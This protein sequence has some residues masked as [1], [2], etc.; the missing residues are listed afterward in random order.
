[1]SEILSDVGTTHILCG[2][3]FRSMREKSR[4]QALFRKGPAS[5]S[6]KISEKT[7]KLSLRH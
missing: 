5:C 1:M 4:Q 2:M 6:K 7:K 3:Y